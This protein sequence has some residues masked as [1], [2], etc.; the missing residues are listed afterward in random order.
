MRKF[1]LRSPV[2]VTGPNCDGLLS[3][4]N[5]HRPVIALVETFVKMPTVVS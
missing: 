5:W 4:P 2:N 3:S 1:Q